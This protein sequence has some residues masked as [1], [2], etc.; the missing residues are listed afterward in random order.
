[1]SNI[2][3]ISFGGVNCYL[4]AADH[5]FVLIDT[6]YGSSRASVERALAGAGCGP[7][8]LRLIVLTHGDFD[9]IGSA[10]YFHRGFGAP[11]AGHRAEAAVFEQGNMGLARSHRPLLAR[12]L[13]PL[14][15]LGRA[16]RFTPDRFL[17]DG[18]SL[19]ADGLDAHV[20]HIPGHS[21][22]S[23]GLLL[24]SGEL[25]C[26]DLFT[27]LKRP[28]LNRLIDDKDA[29]RASLEKLRRLPITTVYPGHGEPFTLADLP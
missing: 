14:I 19:A 12:L 11:L 23:I 18:D 1:M 21:N 9:H 24:A 17:A 7:S 6:G 3:I 2:T 27:N 28:E 20:L 5:G 13:F 15:R 16:D 22:G 8:D 4:V 29:A 26:G 25:F 10:A